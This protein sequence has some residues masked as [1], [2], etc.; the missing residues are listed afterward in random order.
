[1][2]LQVR[3]DIRTT[4]KGLLTVAVEEVAAAPEPPKA[5][6]RVSGVA[7]LLTVTGMLAQGTGFIT[8]PL[9]ARALGAAGRGD[10]Q[11]V[12]LPLALLP[13][14]LGFGIAPYAFRTLPRGKKIEEVIPSLGLPLV[15]VGLVVAACAVPIAD[16][17]ASGRETVRTFLIIGLAFTPI[18]MLVLLLNTCM[19]A[20]ERWRA[21]AAIN[22]IP[23]AVS[24]ISTAVLFAIGDL[25]VATAA[26]AGICGMVLQ[27]VPGIPLVVKA[28]RPTF[29]LALTR[30]SISFGLKSWLGGLAQMANARLDQL[31]MIAFVPARQLGLYAVATTISMAYGLVSGALSPPLMQRVA[32]GERAMMAQAVR[33]TVVMTIALNLVVALVTPVLLPLLYGPQFAGALP[34]ALVLLGASVPLAGASILSSAL[35]A[36]GEPVLPS[37][38][39]GIA[40][41]ITGVGL[42]LLLPSLQGIGA[43]IV[44]LAAYSASFAFQLVVASRRIGAPIHDFL[45]PCR[46]DLDWARGRVAGMTSRLGVAR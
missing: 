9:L 14:L 34:M 45:V 7:A 8:G 43:A 32:A 44:S 23:F 22:M 11:A 41:V 3:A 24:L 20:L 13:P 42:F 30:A 12:V 15:V 5:R 39:E 35:Q 31:V 2:S 26:T 21:V 28:R 10:L 1:M 6:A 46:A 33:M 17:L 16:L 18:T 37:V 27:I 36:D 29:R 4:A 19:M 25:T 40:L 38:A